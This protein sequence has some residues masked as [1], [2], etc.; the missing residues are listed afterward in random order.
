MGYMV[1]WSS[2]GS[3]F[4]VPGFMV[5]YVIIGRPVGL[6]KNGVGKKGEMKERRAIYI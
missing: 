3:V 4:A 5:F 6:V 1:A 2:F